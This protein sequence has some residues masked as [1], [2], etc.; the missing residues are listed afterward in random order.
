METTF[1]VP[2]KQKFILSAISYK[3]FIIRIRF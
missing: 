1:D 2:E 3:I